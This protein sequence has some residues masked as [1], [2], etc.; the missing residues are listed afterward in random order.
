[1]ADTVFLKKQVE[2]YVRGALEKQHGVPFSSK[3]LVLA[4]GGD[5]EFDAVSDD[6]K[7]VTTIKSSSGRTSGGRIP[8][9]KMRAVEAEL[10]YLMLVKAE[11]KMV[12][13]TDPGFYEIMSNRLKGRLAAGL[14]L[15]LV[16]LP[17]SLQDAVTQV[18]LLAS[19][20]VN[21]KL[22]ASKANVAP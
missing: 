15:E 10:Y 18:Q 2:Q 17:K 12:V 21:P 1:M 16:E 6:G 3:K 13:V 22:L 5:H 4:P 14:S 20:E 11:Q 9:G 19:R 8:A 7:I